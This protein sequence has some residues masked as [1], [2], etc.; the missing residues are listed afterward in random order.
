MAHLLDH[1]AINSLAENYIN[2]LSRENSLPSS[3]K[4][5]LQ[6]EK[7][8][9]IKNLAWLVTQRGGRY[10]KFS[11]YEDLMQDGQEALIMALKSYKPGEGNFL[12]W[13]FYYIKT[14]LSRRANKHSVIHFPMAF[15]RDNKPHKMSELPILVDDS[16]PQEKAT[17]N[18]LIL[19]LQESVNNL[20]TLH[21]V[22]IR[23][24]YGMEIEGQVLSQKILF[25]R[26]GLNLKEYR[27]ILQEAQ[28]QLKELL[29]VEE[30]KKD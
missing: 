3:E 16:N 13:A 11:N 18:E 10:K 21:Q 17:E 24:H 26:Y 4:I 6:I 14:K 28:E 23:Q 30:F 20:P 29:H 1:S 15:A 19:K 5:H 25:K 9:C 12:T 7:N 2:L 27:R 8:K 22:V